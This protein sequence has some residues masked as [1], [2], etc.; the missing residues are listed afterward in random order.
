[1]RFYSFICISL[2]LFV[3]GYNL[4][5]TYLQPHSLVKEP[6]TFTTFFEYFFA[7]GLLR[8]RIPLLFLISGYIYALQDA[9]PYLE[10]A[11]KRFKTLLLPYFI[12]SAIGLGVTFLLQHF[13]VTAQAVF[14]AQLDQIGDNRPYSEMSFWDIFKRWLLVPPS[15]QLWFIRNLFFYNLLY[16]FFKMV[17][18]K[19]ALPWFILLF[20]LMLHMFGIFIFEAQ[21]MFFFTFGIWISKS[22]FPIDRKP[23]WCSQNLCWLVF[24]GLAFIKTWMA[25]EFE[26][27]IFLNFIIMN[28]LH[29]VSVIAGIMAIWFSGDKVVAWCMRKRW[30]HWLASFSFVIYGFHVPLL[31]YLTNFLYMQWNSFQYYRLLTFFVAPVLVFFICVALGFVLRKTVPTFYRIATGGRGF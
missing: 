22:Q 17:V 3:H 26:E 23:V 15:F 20:I 10:R 12:W 13:P 7:N 30:F 4:N 11:G 28:F 6:T 2:L 24:V 25:F 5:E 9:R 27:T 31:P 18:T 8:F 21:G 19:Y 29:Y 16:P 1:M 14:N